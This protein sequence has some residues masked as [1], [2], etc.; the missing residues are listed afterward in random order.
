MTLRQY[1]VIMTLATLLCWGAWGFVLFQVD[2]FQASALSFAFFYTSLFL[3]LLGTLSF[4][5]FAGYYFLSREKLPM[6]RY[7]QKSFRDACI[8]SILA[9]AVLYLQAEGWLTLW[10]GTLL[11]TLLFI[12]LLFFITNR[13]TVPKPKY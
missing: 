8:I 11:V 12:L 13:R 4:A 3:S 10:N 6:Y 2:P 7:V 5:A 1:L 9:G